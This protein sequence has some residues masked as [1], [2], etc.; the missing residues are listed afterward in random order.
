MHTEVIGYPELANLMER[1]AS[2]QKDNLDGLTLHSFTLDG[3][4]VRVTVGSSDTGVMFC[5]K[6]DAAAILHAI[7]KPLPHLTLIHGAA[8]LVHA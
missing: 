3:R 2:V 4:N 1:S 8:M 7:S 6:V 5:R